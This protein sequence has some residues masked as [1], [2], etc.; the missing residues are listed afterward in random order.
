MRNLKDTAQNQDLKRL[1]G[2][3]AA[4]YIEDGM[5]CGIGTGSTVAFLIE[6]LGRRC[7][8]EGL[9]IIG[10]PTSFQSK[11]LCQTHGIPTR[12][13]QDCAVLDIAID[14]ADEVDPRL[15]VIKGGGAAQTREKIVAAMARKFIVI[16][17]ESKLS[18]RLGR[19]FPVPIEILPSSL[20][21]VSGVIQ[22]LGG[23]PEL[24]M[25]LR[26]DGPVITD[27]SQFIIDARFDPDK[28]D[29]KAIDAQLHQTPG[30]VET[31]LFYDYTSLV[32]VGQAG[33]MTVGKMTKEKI[34]N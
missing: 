27:N 15:N 14:G 7:R 10:T 5:V 3:A 29:L 1:V 24:R 11:I 22:E 28:W 33:D 21:Y 4:G 26:K 9:R 13:I 31:G 32:L 2:V 25:A 17:D 8:E 6:E 34:D 18:D 20:N 12:D 23:R 30:V 16:V 19:K